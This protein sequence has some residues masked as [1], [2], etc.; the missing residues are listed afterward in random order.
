VTRFHKFKDETVKTRWFFV[1]L[2]SEFA[3]LIVSLPA[4]CG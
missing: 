1:E 3:R 2:D 4:L